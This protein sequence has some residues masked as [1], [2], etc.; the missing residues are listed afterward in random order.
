M[1]ASPPLWLQE[2]TTSRTF[3][4]CGISLGS[5]ILL[6]P[7]AGDFVELIL[8]YLGITVMKWFATCIWN[9]PESR[10]AKSSGYCNRKLKGCENLKSREVRCVQREMKQT[11]VKSQNYIL[12]D[13][14]NLL[15]RSARVVHHLAAKITQTHVRETSYHSIKLHLKQ[16]FRSAY[17]QESGTKL[18]QKTMDTRISQNTRLSKKKGSCRISIVRWAWLLRNTSSPHWN[19]SWPILHAM[20]PPRTH[21]QKPSR[22]MYRVI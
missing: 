2:Y 21:G 6:A 15:G 13:Q 8:L 3:S 16:V 4:N 20:Q 17:R 1:L 11:V 9:G 12:R 5:L 18:S 10:T 7:E 14:I 19:P 22:T